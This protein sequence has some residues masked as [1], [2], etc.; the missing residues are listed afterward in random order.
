MGF[1]VSV[2]VKDFMTAVYFYSFPKPQIC[3][4]RSTAWKWKASGKKHF[5]KND[6]KEGCSCVAN[7]NRKS[8]EKSVNTLFLNPCM[9]KTKRPTSNSVSQIFILGMSD[10]LGRFVG[11]ICRVICRAVNNL[12]NVSFDNQRINLIIWY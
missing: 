4:S 3:S 7:E 11:K 1:T 2:A 8:C 6:Y 12:V 9:A 5:L 10:I